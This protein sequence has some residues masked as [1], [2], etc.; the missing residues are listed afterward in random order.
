MTKRGKNLFQTEDK[1]VAEIVISER[2]EENSESY[3]RLDFLSGGNFW[4]VIQRRRNANRAQQ[5]HELKSQRLE[6]GEVE[7][8]RIWET[9]YP[10]EG[11][12]RVSL[13]LWLNTSL[14]MCQMKTHKELQGKNNYR[15]APK[16]MIYKAQEAFT[17]AIMEKS[18]WIQGALKIDHKRA[19][20]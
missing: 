15:E 11:N 10:R 7:V 14:Y 2:K 17:P 6:L 9:R 12:I 1:E 3:N 19:I 8:S 18:S 4:I 5:T 13:S 20:Y 16:R